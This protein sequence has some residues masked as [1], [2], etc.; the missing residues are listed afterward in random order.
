[1]KI[2][3][4]K[5]HTFYTVQIPKLHGLLTRSYTL[6]QLTPEDSPGTLNAVSIGWPGNLFPYSVSP[7][8]AETYLYMYNIYI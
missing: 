4:N 3:R 1:M 5:L 6:R 8:S 2:K 7:S